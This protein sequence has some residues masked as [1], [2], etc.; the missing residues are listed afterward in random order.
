MRTTSAVVVLAA[1]LTPFVSAGMFHSAVC[2]TYVGHEKVLHPQATIDACKAYRE[3]NEPNC[4]D[5]GMVGSPKVPRVP[6]MLLNT[7]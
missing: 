4:G 3:Q 1:L 6:I 2:I 7:N 5:C